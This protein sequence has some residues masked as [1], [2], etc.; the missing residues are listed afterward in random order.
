MTLS[1]ML[2]EFLE[3]YPREYKRD[4]KTSN[5]YFKDLKVRIQKTLHPIAEEFDLTI[6][7]LGGQGVMRKF[8]Y[9]CFLAV[10][11]HYKT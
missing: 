1:E 9:V 3:R 4:N 6:K 5:P 10:A 8:A 2:I 7:A 11:D